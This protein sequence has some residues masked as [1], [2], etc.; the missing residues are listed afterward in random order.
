[1]E[2]G[3]SVI[4]VLVL[5]LYG[6]TKVQKKFKENNW[7]P[8]VLLLLAILVGSSISYLF[9]LQGK[10]ALFPILIIFVMS[11]FYKGSKASYVFAREKQDNLSKK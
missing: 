7:K 2:Y 5:G 3:L 4:L 9:S 1:M 8:I 10:V 6:I 11:L